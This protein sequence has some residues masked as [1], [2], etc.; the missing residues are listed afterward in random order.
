MYQ[1]EE[2]VKLE[3]NV[4]YRVPQFNYLRV[5]LTQ[6]DELRAEIARRTQLANKCY[7][8]VGTLLKSRSISINLRIKM[9]MTV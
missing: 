8:G 6:D 3:G 5:L 2:S 4:F 7:F 1:L 9:F